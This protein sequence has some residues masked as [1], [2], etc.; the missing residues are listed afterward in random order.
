L[1]GEAM[2][3]KDF[4]KHYIQ[5]NILESI[6]EQLEDQVSII[7]N[8]ADPNELKKLTWSDSE[9]ENF[10]NNADEMRESIDRVLKELDEVIKEKESS[11]PKKKQRAEKKKKDNIIPFSYKVD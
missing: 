2:N 9:K 5:F 3:D 1:P 7:D 11:L 10:L 8:Y 6:K 4:D